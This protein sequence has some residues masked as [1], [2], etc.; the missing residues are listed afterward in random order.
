MQIDHGE[1]GMKNTSLSAPPML[2]SSA[3][4]YSESN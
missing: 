4:V 1:F 2:V 3:S